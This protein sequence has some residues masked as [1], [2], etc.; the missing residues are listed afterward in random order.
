M[1]VIL[2]I[3]HTVVALGLVGLILLNQGKGAEVGASFGSGAS[4]TIFGSQGAAS[5]V[6]KLTTIFAVL[7]FITSLSLGLLTL[8]SAKP[9]SIDALITQA[10]QQKEQNKAQQKKQQLEEQQGIPK[11]P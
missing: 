8:H 10:E 5:F 7:F 6:T 2:L 3:V 4:Q 9:K 11:V 1:E